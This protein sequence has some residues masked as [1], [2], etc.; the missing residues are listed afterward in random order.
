MVKGPIV[1]IYK[2]DEQAA[3]GQ[4]Q[5]LQYLMHLPVMKNQKGQELHPENLILHNNEMGMMFADQVS[6]KLYNFDLE[7]GKVVDE[8][9]WQPNLVSNDIVKVCNERKNCATDTS[10]I[11]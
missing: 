11:F 4:Q 6:K 10:A 5:K 3:I 7:K 2:N 8:I 1:K 9:D